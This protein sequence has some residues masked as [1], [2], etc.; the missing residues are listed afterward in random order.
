[1]RPG[2]GPPL[3]RRTPL[4]RKREKLARAEKVAALIGALPA[5]ERGALLRM[6][7][8]E[9]DKVVAV[10]QRTLERLEQELDA[11]RVDR[12]VVGVGRGVNEVREAVDVDWTARHRALD[13]VLTLLGLYPSRN[14]GESQPKGD[15][16]INILVAGRSERPALPPIDVPA[17]PA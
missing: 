15:T 3:T 11:E 6:A 4:P 16:T 8:W 9:Q 14:A 7:G 12:H 17:N 5:A 1:M 2:P 13:A 10:L